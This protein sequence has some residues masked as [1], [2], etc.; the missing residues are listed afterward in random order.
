MWDHFVFLLPE[1]AMLLFANWLERVGYQRAIFPSY[2]LFAI[3][4]WLRISDD[5]ES[6]L[7]ITMLRLQN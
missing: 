1:L 5:P 7:L 4:R 6:L 3:I 2:V